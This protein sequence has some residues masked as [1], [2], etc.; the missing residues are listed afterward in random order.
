MGV[1]YGM[2]GGEHL[3]A[4]RTHIRGDAALR[5]AVRGSDVVLRGERSSRLPVEIWCAPTTSTCEH[6]HTPTTAS[7]RSSPTI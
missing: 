6:S 7:F 5:G 2:T 4:L 1:L 3:P